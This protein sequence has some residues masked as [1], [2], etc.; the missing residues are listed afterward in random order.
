[1]RN[2]SFSRIDKLFEKAQVSLVNDATD[3]L[4]LGHGTLSNRT[5][6]CRQDSRDFA[7]I[8]YSIRKI[9]FQGWLLLG[10]CAKSKTCAY[11]HIQDF[12]HVSKCTFIFKGGPTNAFGRPLDFNPVMIEL[13]RLSVWR[14]GDLVRPSTHAQ[15]ARVEKEESCGLPT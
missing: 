8:D 14:A 11:V 6:V 15:D 2:P 1:M 13:F 12:V 5:W 4:T 9:E 7:R 10:H 3:F